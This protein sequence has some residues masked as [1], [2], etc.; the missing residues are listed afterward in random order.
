MGHVS[1]GEDVDLAEGEVERFQP[2]AYPFQRGFRRRPPLRAPVF[3]EAPNAL[4][5]IRRLDQI[6]WHA[7]PP[8]EEH[9]RTV[10]ET[11]SKATAASPRTRRSRRWRDPR[12]G[13]G[14]CSHGGPLCTP[15]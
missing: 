14:G 15:R 7:T 10:R 2:A 1:N 12:R 8:N 11:R 13:G 6:L 3:H 4:R 5:G 9:W